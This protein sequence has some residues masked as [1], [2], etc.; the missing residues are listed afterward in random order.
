MPYYPA[1]LD[2]TG[3]DALIVGNGPAAAGK[4]ERLLGAGA[5]VTVLTAEPEAELR[6]L[7]GRGRIRLESRA[8]RPG[9]LRGYDLAIVAVDDRTVQS[10]IAR[11]ARA[12]RVLVNVIDVPELC[13]FVAP[14][15]LD[16]GDVQIAVGTSGAAPA[17]AARLRDRIGDVCGAELAVVADIHRRVRERLRERDWPIERRHRALRGLANSDLAERVKAGDSPGVDRLLAEH[18]DPAIDLAAL[19]VALR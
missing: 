11:E 17:L 6:A 4:I 13:G 3:R 9:D 12:E 7:A 10:A 8:Y 14:A 16:R 1:F 2:L 5:R 18:V 19:G 15:I